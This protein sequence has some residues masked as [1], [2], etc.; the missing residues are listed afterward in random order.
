[1]L[2]LIYTFH[3]YMLG[4]AHRIQLVPVLIRV[5]IPVPMKMSVF[6]PV[7]VLMTWYPYSWLCTRTLIQICVCSTRIRTHS[8]WSVPIP[9][10]T[11]WYSYPPTRS[12]ARLHI[13]HYKTAT[14]SG[15]YL[16]LFHYFVWY[17]TNTVRMLLEILLPISYS[18]LLITSIPIPRYAG[19]APCRCVVWLWSVGL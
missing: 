5:L 18:N 4:V 19:S 11:T 13:P 3:C 17:K 2:C 9:V 1:M 6:V 8:H 15:V 7:P 10:L 12:P 14:N 16:S